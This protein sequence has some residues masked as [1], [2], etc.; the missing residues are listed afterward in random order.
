MGYIKHMKVY[1]IPCEVSGQV[2]LVLSSMHVG[3][4]RWRPRLSQWHVHWSWATSSPVST[5]MGDRQGRLSAVSLSPFVGVGLNLWP[6]VHIA[7]IVL[8]RTLINQ[9]INACNPYDS[10]YCV[11]HNMLFLPAPIFTTKMNLRFDS[12]IN[13]SLAILMIWGIFEWLY[14]Y[15]RELIEENSVC[16]FMCV[17][18]IAIWKLRSKSIY[19]VWR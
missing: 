2:F 13:E 17:S 11:K 18:T 7:V 3:G 8:T 12:Y 4:L 5:W 19:Y 1:K 10:W 6:T 15:C 16:Q 9:S 14:S